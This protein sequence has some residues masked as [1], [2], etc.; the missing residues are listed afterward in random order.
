M[1]KVKSFPPMTEII[2]NA[3]LHY[4]PLTLGVCKN[5]L[6]V[7]HKIL[8]LRFNSAEYVVYLNNA[9]LIGYGQWWEISY[10]KSAVSAVSS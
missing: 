9:T 3:S 1:K 4:L 8:L 10:R 6:T 5:S 7:L 2:K